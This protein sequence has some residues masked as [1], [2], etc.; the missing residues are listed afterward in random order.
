V[1]KQ[2]KVIWSAGARTDLDDI[3]A[4][5]AKDSPA[6][7]LAFLEEVLHTKKRESL[8]IDPYGFKRL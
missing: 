7:A 3:I 8:L 2:R 6:G 4:Y 1:A 5:I